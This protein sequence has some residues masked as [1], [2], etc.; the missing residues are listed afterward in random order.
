MKVETAR[1]QTPVFLLGVV[2]QVAALVMMAF[3]PVAHGFGT[4][5]LSLGA[6]LLLLGILLPI[7]ALSSIPSVD[8]MITQLKADSTKYLGWLFCVLVAIATYGTTLEPTASLWDCSETIASAYKLQVPHTPGTPL[9]L[10]IGRVFSM[11][12]L[13]DAARVAW[14]VNFMS[15]TFSALAVGWVYL[16]V[17][18]FGTCLS[19]ERRGL[20]IGSCVGALC[21]AFSD[22]FWFSAV[23]AETYGPSIFCMLLLMGLSLRARTQMG[24][25][26]SRALLRL[27]YLFGLSYCIHPMCILVLP[28]CVLIIWIRD[29]RIDWKQVIFFLIVGIALVLLISKAIAVS[30]FEWAFKMD[31]WLVN[32]WSFPFYS[33]VFVL[34]VVFAGAMYGLGRRFE[35][36]RVFLACFALT[37]MGFSPYLM[38]FIR[39]SHLPPINEFS[40]SNL[41][42]IKPYMNRESYPSRPLLYGRFFDAALQ[43]T[44]KKADRYVVDGDRYKAVGE[45]PNY[46]YDKERMTI[47]P[48][49]YSGDPS[50]IKIYK[51]WTGLPADEAPRFRHNLIFM[52]RYQL[53]HMFGRYFMWNFAGRSGDQ[54]HAAWLAPWD[55]AQDRS[56]ITY[57]RANNHYYML[58]L[59]LG[60][61][62]AV[63]Q[64]R[65]D[66]K[67]FLVNCTF[68]LITG[69]LLALYLNATPNEPRERD[70]I[71]VGCY[72]A[73]SIWIGLGA[74]AGAAVAL[75][76]KSGLALALLI[77]GI[78]IWMLYQ[79]WDDH[80]RANR[81]FHM[82][83]ARNVLGSCAPGAILFTGGDNDTF[84]LWYLQEVEGFRTDVRV[85]VMSYFNADWYINQL[86]RAYYDS[87]AL[88][89]S[90]K[91]GP[92]QYGPFDPL[93]IQER[94]ESA[95]SWPKYVE[96][97]KTKHPQLVVENRSGGDYFILPSRL[98]NL[99]TS[100][101]SLAITIN[102]S[103][104]PKNELAILDILHS[105]DWARPIYFNFTSLNG[106]KL[107]LDSYL[108]QEGLVYRLKP[109]LEGKDGID[110]D[111]EQSYDNLVTRANYSN[112]AESSV[113]FNHEDYQTRMIV[114]LKFTF[115]SLIEAYL[116]KGAVDRA[117]TL[118]RFAMENLYWD[119]LEPS[120]ADIQLGRVLKALGQSARAE[121]LVGTTFHFFEQVID[122]RLMAG[123]SPSQNEW[124]IFREAAKLLD[125]PQRSA[126]YQA[127]VS[128]AQEAKD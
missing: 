32:K 72:A 103:Y 16:I 111:L 76:I 28:V 25:D 112:L 17:W 82:D 21:L 117:E 68:F 126:R 2:L 33:G 61:L 119:H 110:L 83:H 23:E 127:L 96:A 124:L 75:R 45:I 7:L 8:A 60:C 77:L 56:S 6:S 38:L 118:I 5:T 92:N 109:P 116:E 106:L 62:G 15:A 52:L 121:Q 98:I 22:S 108:T 11:L 43:S 55:P 9:T 90:L 104:L 14:Y 93:Y 91:N 99:P 89:L 51:E 4:L 81:T 30:L 42:K 26:R 1:H 49:I 101:G 12:A 40:P 114:P 46:H 84:P 88:H 37:V 100:K 80:N 57:S 107:K 27:S 41:A 13:G 105:N 97:L 71:Y 74:M 113:Y 35:R 39:S 29:Q 125:D 58:P 36:S 102:G 69:V 120:Y 19:R 70:Y 34:I 3:D 87:P 63:V 50:H 53:G 47:L 78:P 115:N 20:L 67:G 65:R 54:Q 18:H 59:L 31:L 10:L 24:Y 64:Y 123:M 128:R 122:E 48:R 73:F 86:S 66:R 44:S 79:N 94:T 95:I 85:K